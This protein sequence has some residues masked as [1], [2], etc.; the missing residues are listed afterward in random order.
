VGQVRRHAGSRSVSCMVE[1]EELCK[2][3][4]RYGD[5]LMGSAVKAAEAERWH[6]MP[7]LI[8]NLDSALSLAARL[9][10]RPAGGSSNPG[11]PEELCE[12]LRRV[13]KRISRDL[14]RASR[15]EKLGEVVTLARHLD[16]LE[17]LKWRVCR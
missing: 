9:K 7:E 3:L 8:A 2:A 13:S 11:Q 17:R 15:A 10:C 1:R 6:L 14:V 12:Q 16:V 4:F 5:A